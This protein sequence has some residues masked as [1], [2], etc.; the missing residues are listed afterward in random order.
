ML[1]FTIGASQED[2]VATLPYLRYMSPPGRG[3]S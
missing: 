3:Y 2:L 1:R